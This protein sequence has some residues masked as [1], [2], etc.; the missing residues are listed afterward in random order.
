MGS[1]KTSVGKNLAKK[2]SKK[3]IDLDETIQSKLGLS[4][5]EIFKKYGETFFR[6]KEAEILK[7]ISDK[8]DHIISLGGGTLLNAE[9]IK[10]IKEM[11][12]VVYLKAELVTLVD[13]LLTDKTHRPLIDGIDFMGIENL[14]KLR[15][16]GYKSADLEV[17]TENLTVTQVSEK[18]L[19]SL[20]RCQK[21]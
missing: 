14:F 1:G 15:K 13:R 2:L 21:L 11:G 16:K 4:I 18:I 8:K 19:E 20:E 5:Q 3:Y 12:T 17:D 10:T 7:I 9:N 6:E